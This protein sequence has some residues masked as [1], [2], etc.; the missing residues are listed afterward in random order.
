MSLICFRSGY[1]SLGS[2]SLAGM[3]ELAD[4][5]DSKSAEVP[6]SWGFNS[7]SR[8]QFAPVGFVC[9]GVLLLRQSSGSGFRLRPRTP[10]K[11]LKFNSP[12][13]HHPLVPVIFRGHFFSALKPETTR[14]ATTH[15]SH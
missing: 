6:P 14:R 12:S 13:R 2:T 11:R 7:P 3:A 15:D 8:H 1:V 10:A 4:G 5:A 9:I